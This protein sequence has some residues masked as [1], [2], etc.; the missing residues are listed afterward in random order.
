MSTRITR[1]RQGDVC[2]RVITLR[3]FPESDSHQR[4][5]QC[6]K[7]EVACLCRLL[8]CLGTKKKT[9]LELRLRSVVKT[10]LT[11]HLSI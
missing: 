6:A 9:P 7:M 11:G 5:Q 3:D 4:P 8:A 2:A 1:G 10:T